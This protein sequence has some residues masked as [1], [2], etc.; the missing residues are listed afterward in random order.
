MASCSENDDGREEDDNEY[1]QDSFINDNESEENAEDD[2]LDITEAV[3]K[4][5][6]KNGLNLRLPAWP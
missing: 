3:A 4:A 1:I 6:K 5:L 2:E